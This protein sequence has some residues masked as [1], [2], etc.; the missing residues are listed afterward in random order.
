MDRIVMV[1]QDGVVCDRNYQTTKDIKN[2]IKEL[3][4]ANL[5]IVPNSDTPVKRLIYNFNSMLG[6]VPDII[7]AEKGAVVSFRGEDF[8]LG[9][10]GGLQE[11]LG[12][13]QE[14][15]SAIGIKVARG[16][17]ATWIKEYKIFE[18]EQ[19]MLI[20]DGLR[21]QS[22]G[23]YLR[24]TDHNGLPQINKEWAE[25]GIRVALRLKWPVN[26]DIKNID[27]NP[28]Y[29]IVI[30]GAKNV[31]KTMGY[32]FLRK[33]FLNTTFYMI[34]DGDAD[35]I[36]DE[37]VVHCA[38]ANADDLLKNKAAYVSRKPFTEGLEDCLRWVMAN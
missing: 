3:T 22:V 23:F 26:L 19:R 36:G 1:D 11:F 37:T 9:K 8:F 4:G 32:M 15:F 16:D 21:Q 33:R 35:V 31:D 20:I 5:K 10:I 17:S 38:V 14:T 6:L 34:G 27:Y 24:T 30:C 13:L 25:F 18:P 2:C 28:K 12:E 7:I 29:G